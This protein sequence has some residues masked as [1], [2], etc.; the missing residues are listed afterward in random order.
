[1]RNR[2]VPIGLQHPAGCLEILMERLA[3]TG[4]NSLSPCHLTECTSDTSYQFRRHQSGLQSNSTSRDWFCVP[5][6]A[7]SEVPSHQRDRNRSTIS[8]NHCEIREPPAPAFGPE[9]SIWEGC[10][11]PVG[12]E[13][14]PLQGTRRGNV[15]CHRHQR[16]PTHETSS[17]A[18]TIFYSLAPVGPPQRKPSRVVHSVR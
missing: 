8:G 12:P 3:R 14:L 7:S 10:R 1:V 11:V 5:L 13:H 4:S 18:R 2:A 6:E 9:V 15:P 16:T 17:P